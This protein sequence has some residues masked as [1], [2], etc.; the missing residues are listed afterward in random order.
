MARNNK[1]DNGNSNGNNGNGNGNPPVNNGK[2]VI[3]GTDG[4]DTLFGGNGKDVLNGLGGNDTLDGG[5]GK[6]TMSGGAG[7][8]VYIFNQPKEAVIENADE[9]NDTVFSRLS[10][11][12][13]ANVENLTLTG[14]VPANGT[15][16]DLDNI[17]T[18]NTSK[19][20]LVGGLGNDTLDGGGGTDTLNGGAGNDTYIVDDASDK[21][22][23]SAGIDTVQASF[24]YTLAANLENLVLTGTADI[25]GTGNA[26][27]N[28][29]TGNAGVNILT[30]LG[31]ND[32]LDGGAG[33]DTMIGGTGNDTF[34]VDD[35][36]DVVTELPGEGTDTVMSSVSFTA[37]G[38]IENVTL[39]GTADIN[40]TG[41]DG[42]NVLTGNAGVNVLTGLGGNDTLD[43]GAGA[44]T[45]VGGTGNDTYVVDNAGDI[46]T[47]L[48]GEG[49]D[50]VNASVTYTLTADVENLNLT[51]TGNFGGNGNAS[52][53]VITGNSGNNNLNG[54]GGA[55]TI[56]GG[57]GD[58]KIYGGSG[59]DTVTGSDGMDTFVFKS[60]TAYTSVDTVTDFDAVEGDKLDLSNLLTSFD[61]LTMALTDW[62]RISDSGSDSIV[63]VDRDGLGAGFSF[64]QIATLSGVTGLTDEDALATSGTLI[65]A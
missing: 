55:D 5:N 14:N 47:E 9:G 36:G 52:A 6:D 34:V 44:D 30:G 28:V 43:G 65:I 51:G 21:I 58:D 49:A 12:L 40:A 31:G 19:N 32:T 33:A 56:D 4:D 18:G 45:M 41:D 29:I 23:D 8:D 53:N 48:P 59:A 16:N 38:N 57:L 27:D 24:S 54:N 46:V 62:V 3:T 63:E 64:T 20:I 15:G 13:G 11:T 37:G 60:T 10:Y 17:L 1:P 2:N 7:D 39:T 35:A 26:S 61:P 25:N 50:T 42:D 22:I